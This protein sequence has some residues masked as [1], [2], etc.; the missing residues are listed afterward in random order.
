MKTEIIDLMIKHGNTVV[1]H[2]TKEQTIQEDPYYSMDE[3][4]IFQLGSTVGEENQVF[5]Y[6]HNNLVAKVGVSSKEGM[7]L[8]EAVDKYKD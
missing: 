5:Y 1:K 3:D 7:R 8:F 4:V 6:T 2:M